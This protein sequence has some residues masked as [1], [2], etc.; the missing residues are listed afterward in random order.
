MLHNL[1]LPHLRT[2]STPSRMSLTVSVDVKHNVYLLTHVTQ[3]RKLRNT[4]CV[5]H[6]EIHGTAHAENER[7]L[8]QATFAGLITCFGGNEIPVWFFGCCFL[9]LSLFFCWCLYQN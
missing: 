2:P 9:V 5:L 1:T 8:L 3:C 7:T 6:T 4:L